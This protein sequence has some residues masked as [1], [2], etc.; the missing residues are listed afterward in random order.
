MWRGSS[1]WGRQIFGRLHPEADHQ[2]RAPQGQPPSTAEDRPLPA[3]PNGLPAGAGGGPLAAARAAPL[4][5]PPTRH[6]PPPRTRRAVKVNA[7]YGQDSRYVDLT[8]S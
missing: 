6:R 1:A 5:L 8:V 4:P 3:P 2:P 7:K